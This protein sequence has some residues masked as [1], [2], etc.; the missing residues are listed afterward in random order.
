MLMGLLCF[1]FS[2]LFCIFVAKFTIIVCK[3]GKGERIL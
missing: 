1:N 3:D 2:A